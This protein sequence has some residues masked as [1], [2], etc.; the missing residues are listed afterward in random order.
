[1]SEKKYLYKITY[2]FKK[3]QNKLL[4]YGFSF[5]KDELGEESLYAQ[6]IV[7]PETGSIFAYLKRAV[8][9]IY[10]HA[11]TEERQA[12]FKDYE[13]TEILTEDQKR[14]YV[15]TVTDDIKK[16]FTQA[17]LCVYTSGE[18]AWCLFINAPDRV[19]Y[20]NAKTLEEECKGVIDKLLEYKV[21]RKARNRIK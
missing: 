16:E 19:Q 20:Y 7:L 11:T 10:T 4:E 14:D 1:M 13:F 5:Y 21:I 3:S 6:P 15:L 17:Q 8:E 12:D 2:P 9:K 18:G